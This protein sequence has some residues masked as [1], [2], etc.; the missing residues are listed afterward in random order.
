MEEWRKTEDEDSEDYG[1]CSVCKSPNRVTPMPRKSKKDPNKLPP[2]VEPYF[3]AW[4]RVDTWHTAHLFDLER[5]Y[6]FVWAVHRYCRP[7]KGSTTSRKRLPSDTAIR[8]AIYEARKDTFNNEYLEQLSREYASIYS[9]LLD[10]AN[11]PNHPDHLIEK[12][13]ILSYYHHLQ[14]D[15]GGYAADPKSIAYRMTLDWGNDW[16]EKLEKERRRH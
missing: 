11:T 15:L 14:I 9:H 4:I 8:L 10:S 1:L 3:Q 2:S 13:N 12:K 7:R 6:K 5:F 16:K